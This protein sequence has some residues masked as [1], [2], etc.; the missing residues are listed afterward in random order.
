LWGGENI[1]NLFRFNRQT[2]LVTEYQIEVGDTL[3]GLLLA[4]VAYGYG[5]VPLFHQR[6]PHTPTWMPADDILLASVIWFKLN[7]LLV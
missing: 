2:V 5:I 4:E 1:I 7:H 6:S 3:N